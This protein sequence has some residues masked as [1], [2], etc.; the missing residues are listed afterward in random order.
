MRGSGKNVFPSASCWPTVGAAGATTSRRG[1]LRTPAH[2]NQ[3]A[4]G[5]DLGMASSHRACGRRLEPDT[6][7]ERP[8][9][10]ARVDDELDAWVPPRDRL[11]QAGAHPLTLPVRMHRQIGNEGVE[12]E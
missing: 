6:L 12:A 5:L 9:L 8:R 10:V 2:S 7:P 3:Q 11:D 4:R 1:S